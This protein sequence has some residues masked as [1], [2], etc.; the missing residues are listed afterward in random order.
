MTPTKTKP[1]P[2]RSQEQRSAETRERLFRATLDLICEVGFERL[3]TAM[4]ARRAGV[5]KGAQTHHF[6]TRNDLLVG[7]FIYLTEIWER[8]RIAFEATQ[9]ERI[10][11]EDY[12]R[13]LWRD[14]FSKP[15][16]LASIELMLA[17]RGDVDLRERIMAVLDD[18]IEIRDTAFW[19]SID[20]NMSK[21]DASAFMH[22]T[23][24]VLRGMATNAS[25]NRDA[26][27]NDAVFETWLAMTRHYL[28]V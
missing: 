5:S 19:T 28:K 3:T 2:R 14:I 17:A 7:A 18:W 27:E 20:L 8:A 25:F 21:Q 6:P 12:I 4:I 1:A 13:Y 23:L 9:P 22:L 26:T 15:V 24:S 16:Y 11:L 10:P